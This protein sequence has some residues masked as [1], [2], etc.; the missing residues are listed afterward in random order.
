MGFEGVRSRSGWDGGVR[1]PLLLLPP[2]TCLVLTDQTFIVYTAA[3]LGLSSG[4]Q[5]QSGTEMCLKSQGP[6]SHLLGA[7]LGAS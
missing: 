2:T 1:D 3:G 6:A 5:C 7:S 4:V